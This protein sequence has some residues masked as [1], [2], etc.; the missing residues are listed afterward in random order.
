MSWAT[1]ICLWTIWAL[2]FLVRKHLGRQT[3][4]D[5]LISELRF[6]ALALPLAA[7]AMQA[8]LWYL[9]LYRGWQL[10]AIESRESSARPLSIRDYMIGTGI[11]AFS[12]SAARLAVKSSQLDNEY[13]AG[14][15]IFCAS[16]AGISLVSVAPAMLLM[17]G[18]HDWRFGWGVLVLYGAV[19]SSVIIALIEIG[20][21][22]LQSGP[23]GLDLWQSVGFVIVFTSFGAFLGLGLKALRDMGF[24]LVVGRQKDFA[25]GRC[26]GGLY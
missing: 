16:A 17:F 11:V 25:G 23:A 7:L 12:I 14:W 4:G 9:R 20:V 21:P 2:G 19:A 8:L 15:S 5:V 18:C 24:S 22:L 26:D 6:G 13:W 3:T 1:A 10:V